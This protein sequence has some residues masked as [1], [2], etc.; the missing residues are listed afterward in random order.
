VLSADQ[1]EDLAAAA[2]SPEQPSALL[3]GIGRVGAAT[4]GQALFTAMRFDE[5]A[6]EVERLHSSDPAAY[7]LGGRK[8]KRD[9]AWGRHVLIERR[10]FVGEGE[11]AIRAAFDDHALILGLGLRCVINVPVVFAARCHGT[12]NFLAT[13]AAVSSEDVAP[14]RLLALI[15]AP[16]LASAAPACAPQRLAG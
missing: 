13:R 2:A 3:Q 11:E 8:R 16:A 1:I 7:P 15:A 4:I 12:L 14:A 5:D 10:V 9:T 6:M